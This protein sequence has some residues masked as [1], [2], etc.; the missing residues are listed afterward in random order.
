MPLSAP[1]AAALPREHRDWRPAALRSLLS[2]RQSRGAL[3]AGRIRRLGEEFRDDLE[4]FCDLLVGVEKMRRDPENPG[5]PIDEDAAV[6]ELLLEALRIGRADHHRA[7]AA[8]GL[9]GT[10]QVP[11]SFERRLDDP[12][13]SSARLFRDRGE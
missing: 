12:L 5:P 8:V 2:L 3:P 13:R 10:L 6:G 7:A 9:D 11:A 1:T 4:G